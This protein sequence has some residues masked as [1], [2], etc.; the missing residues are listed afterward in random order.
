MNT[1]P[2]R[3]FGHSSA[4]LAALLLPVVLAFGCSSGISGHAP[5]LAGVQSQSPGT[6]NFPLA[7]VKRPAPSMNAQSDIDARDLI[8]S[9]TGGDL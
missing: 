2:I 5:G 8:T 1:L 3:D 6:L 4:K 9:T 7:Y